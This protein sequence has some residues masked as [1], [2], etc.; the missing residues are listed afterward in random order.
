MRLLIIE[1]QW[2]WSSVI[3]RYVSQ[4]DAHLMSLGLKRTSYV[5]ASCSP[6]ATICGTLEWIM[7]SRVSN[8]HFGL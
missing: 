6:S 3:C 1:N 8:T 5:N 2:I 4:R 7:K